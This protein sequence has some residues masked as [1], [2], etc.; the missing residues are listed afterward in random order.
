ML[1]LRCCGFIA[2]SFRPPS[3]DEL[4]LF[5]ASKR[6]VT[7]KKRHPAWCLPG[8]GQPLLC[9]LNSGIHADAALRGLSTTIHR[10]TGGPGRAAGH[11]GPHSVC[12][13]CVAARVRE[14]RCPTLNRECC[15]ALLRGSAIGQESRSRT[16]DCD[17]G[18][19]LLQESG[20]GKN[21]PRLPGVVLERLRVLRPQD[22]RCSRRRSLMKP[23][24]NSTPKPNM[25]SAAGS[26]TAATSVKLWSA[27]VPHVHVYVPGVTPRLAKFAL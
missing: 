10:R 6:D 3:E 12:N 16:D 18:M 17:R 13:R 25:P 5:C 9:C 4:L 11:P 1:L 8:I 27:P 24:I 19:G 21:N 2:K 22:C 7:K 26:G 20:S 15:L 14:P 23:P